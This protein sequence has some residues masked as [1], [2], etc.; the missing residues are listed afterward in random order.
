[1]CHW[2]DE[3]AQNLLLLLQGDGKVYAAAHSSAN[4]PVTY[5]RCSITLYTASVL[6][7]LQP[8]HDVAPKRLLHTLAALAGV[9]ADLVVPARLRDNDEAVRVTACEAH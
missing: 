9:K 5:S 1:M 3:G 2:C 7:A 4:H 8:L 6:I